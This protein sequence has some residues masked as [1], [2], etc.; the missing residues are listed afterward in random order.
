MTFK[1]SLIR[2]SGLITG[3]KQSINAIYIESQAIEGV[4]LLNDMK[5]ISDSGPSTTFSYGANYL[6]YESYVVFAS[7]T[8]TNIIMA[9]SSVFV[10]LI[11]VTGNLLMT[12][13]VV[14]CVFLVDLF[15]FGLMS[16]WN[17]ALNS[18]TV[19]NIVIAI[20]LA[21]DYNAHIAHAYL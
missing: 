13:F 6:T 11:L 9:L 21:V 17:V 14:L 12:L 18:I 7:E 19:I 15:L 5:A 20:G 4:Q 10:I 2:N 1:K 16:F 3:Y 8:M